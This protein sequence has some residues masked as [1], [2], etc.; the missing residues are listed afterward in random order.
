MSPRAKRFG[1]SV[2]SAVTHRGSAR[3]MVYKGALHSTRLLKFKARLCAQA[4]SRQVVLLLD[5]LRVHPSAPVKEWLALYAAAITAHHLPSFSPERNPAERL[6]RAWKSKL[7]PRPAPREAK[8]LH[9]P[10]LAH[11]PSCHKP[12]VLIRSSFQSTTTSS[13]A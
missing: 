10:T 12:P 6:H 4:G 3:W 8:Q 9:R 2:R 13:A 11:R 5:N 1:F 7:S